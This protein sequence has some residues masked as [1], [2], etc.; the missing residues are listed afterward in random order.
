[1]PFVTGENVGPYR[2]IEKLG[3]GGMATVYKAYHAALDR[4]VALK[5]LHPAFRE[6]PHFLERFHRE[7]KLV[8]RL[9]HSNIVPIYDF[10]EH[11]GQPYL[12]MKFIH[13]QTLKSRLQI[14]SINLAEGNQILKAVGDALTYAHENGILHR[15]VKPSNILLA[16]D[17][18]Y[19]LA[20]FGLARIAE[21]GASTL[22]GDMLMGTPHYISPEQARGDKDLDERTDIYSLGIVLYETVVGRVP[23]SADTPFSIIHDHIYTPLPLP[24]EVNPAVPPEIQNVLLKALAKDREDRFTT[25][26]QMVNAYLGAVEGIGSIDIP[27]VD[28]SDTLSREIERAER[29]RVVESEESGEKVQIP[30]QV[31]KT[32]SESSVKTK[33]KFKWVWATLGIVITCV[34]LM[35]M[36]AVTNR[37]GIKTL[38]GDNGV[39]STPTEVNVIDVPIETEATDSPVLP[40]PVFTEDP[41]EPRVFPTVHL[42]RAE[43]LVDEGKH[44]EASKE[45]MIA[46]ELFLQ[47][48]QPVNASGAL[49]QAAILSGELDREGDRKL[50]SLLTQAL[51]YS[52]PFDEI[53]QLAEAIPSID[54]QIPGIQVLEARRLIFTGDYET[55]QRILDGALVGDQANY[56]VKVIMAE[57]L[58]TQGDFEGAN[59]LISEVINQP[60]M[61]PWLRDHVQTLEGKISTELS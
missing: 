11:E 17:G 52:A 30:V 6:D 61:H 43:A 28:L 15:D 26:K 54:A 13:G 5:V 55:A 18:R 38:F 35:A 59:A 31:E 57:L 8:A 58:Y 41:E 23:F 60:G 21:L 47:L 20:D 14:G 42:K 45:Y 3:Q 32:T 44:D 16:D 53:D 22:S 4:N 56:L 49:I 48:D 9:E 12:V 19:Y 25:A 24:C 46:G 50:I 27:P 40:T 29:K 2:I 39:E 34:S 1:M 33:K 10:A 37:P 36:V 7:A 51:F